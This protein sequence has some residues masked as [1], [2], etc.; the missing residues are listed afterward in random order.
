MAAVSK[1]GGEAFVVDG[2]HARLVALADGRYALS[3]VAVDNPKTDFNVQAYGKIFN[4]DAKLAKSFSAHTIDAGVS[5]NFP[6]IT[7]LQT[8]GLVIAWEQFASAT[9]DDIHLRIIER[10]GNRTGAETIANT[11]TFDGQIS[12]DMTTL[13]NGNFVVAF[14]DWS[15]FPSEARAQIFTPSGAKVGTEFKLNGSPT[16]ALDPV[17]TVAALSNGNFVALWEDEDED[18]SDM[19][20]RGQVFTATGEPPPGGAEFRVNT[21]TNGSQADAA[22]TRLADGKFV[23]VWTDDQD[24]SFNEAGNK[25][26]SGLK[27]QLFEA[28]GAKAGG[29]FTVA[30]NTAGNQSDA[31]VAT[32][33]DGRFVIVWTNATGN[34]FDG[35][36][37]DST[38]SAAIYN[39]D[40]SVSVAAFTVNT[41]SA[42]QQSASSAAVLADGRIV[43]SWLTS[44][45]GAKDGLYTQIFDPRA[46][47]IDIDGSPLLGD[48]LIGGKFAD[49]IDGLGGKDSLFGAEGK[50]SLTGG[51]AADR[52]TGGKQDD[53]FI[54]TDKTDSGVGN[55]KRDI[56][57]DFAVASSKEQ[58]DL[59]ALSAKTFKWLGGDAFS[60]KAS[61]EVRYKFEGTNKTIVEVDLDKDKAAE[62]QIE[63]SGHFALS[64]GDFI[65]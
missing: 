4:A 41:T 11:T 63:L 19:S 47:G 31:S 13:T 22:A 29:E 52:L 21:T 39:A 45:A 33:G 57:T 26:Y 59:S 37:P 43:F 42:G 6:A 56:I 34:V 8:G 60:N 2:A 50:D 5:H 17:P 23:V 20:I 14:S 61:V 24:P 27:G 15:N 48:Q 54:F 49:K 25:V 28:D 62:M 38:I 7:A 35:P 3:Y 46:A 55:G 36:A 30:L 40:G 12:V 44:E 1:W 16:D 32:L 64:K 10:S 65:L 53:R 18:G 51:A 9:F 58:I